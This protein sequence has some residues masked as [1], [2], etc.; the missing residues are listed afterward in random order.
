[1]A[2]TV[3]VSKCLRR[4]KNGIGFR[5]SNLSHRIAPSN[6]TAPNL[7]ITAV[8]SSASRCRDA[9]RPRLAEFLHVAP[10]VTRK[11]ELLFFQTSFD[12]EQIAASLS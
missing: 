11:H 9:A 7:L 8:R 6:F 5:L 1:M 3:D 10:S 2:P 12:S 4:D